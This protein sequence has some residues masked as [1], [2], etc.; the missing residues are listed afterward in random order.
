MDNYTRQLQL[1]DEYS[2]TSIAAGQQAILDAYA[3]GRATDIGAGQYLLAKAY[4]VALEDYDKNTPAIRSKYKTLLKSID[5]SVIVMSALRVVLDG[6][7]DHVPRTLQQ[8][9][10]ALGRVYES[11]AMLVALRKVSAEY[12]QRTVDYLDSKATKSVSH[13]YRTFLSAS[14]ALQLDWQAWTPT[15]R[16]GAAKFV[17]TRIYESTGLFKWVIGKDGIYTLHPSESLAAHFEDM[18]AS[19]KALTKYPPMLVPPKNWEGFNDGGYLTEWYSI[20]SPMCTLPY[21]KSAD[22]KWVIT[23]LTDERT[24]SLRDAMNKAQQVPYR[25]N[26]EVLGVLRKA[27]AMRVGIMGLPSQQPLPKPDFPFPKSWLKSDATPQELD[28][29]KLWKQQ[30]SNWY[31]VEAK[32]KGRTTGILSKLQEMVRYQDEEALY[33]PTFIDWRGRLYFRSVLNPQSNDSVKGVLEFANGKAL[34]TDGLFWLKV[35]VANSCGY[36]KHS[37]DIKA[38]WCDDNWDMIQDFI[39]NPL[40]VDAP[41]P[42]TAFTLLAAGLALQEALELDD[43]STYICHVPVAMDATCS[44]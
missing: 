11:E 17:L 35:H 37:P 31:T 10:V 23:N 7:T 26:K 27:V 43:P 30:V 36:D 39:N 19:A 21:M 12:T 4:A 42:E 24:A 44:G 25:I 20:H 13:R 18:V 28:R 14:K 6:C 29:F 40:E 22:R 16:I 41:E 38:Q 34:G 5:S 33:F 3:T 1:E 32:R 8:V 9:V 15:E 2:T